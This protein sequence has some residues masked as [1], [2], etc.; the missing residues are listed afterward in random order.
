MTTGGTQAMILAARRPCRP[1]PPCAPVGEY[2]WRRHVLAYPSRWP[3]FDHNGDPFL[4]ETRAAQRGF[5]LAGGI[6]AAGPEDLVE[7]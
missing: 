3:E 7:P 2:A 1:A 6:C 5:D 4:S